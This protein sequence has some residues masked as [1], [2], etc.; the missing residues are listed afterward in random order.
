ML[1]KINGFYNHML[2]KM[3]KMI[4]LVIW[5]E[6]YPL[7][8]IKYKQ[9][10]FNLFIQSSPGSVDIPSY[11]TG[12]HETS[13]DLHAKNTG[14][15]GEK[16]DSGITNIKI[17]KPH[18]HSETPN[19]IA[20]NIISHSVDCTKPSNESCFMS[21]RVV[22]HEIS[23][24]SDIEKGTKLTDD[25]L[26]K[27]LVIPTITMSPVT[28]KDS[29]FNQSNVYCFDSET[30]TVVCTPP[31]GHDYIQTSVRNSDPN[32]GVHTFVTSDNVKSDNTS[33]AV[34]NS[35]R[36]KLYKGNIPKPIVYDQFDYRLFCLK[37]LFFFK[38]LGL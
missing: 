17:Q 5:T 22:S 7:A 29:Q 24:S 18:S 31:D 23:K 27:N 37:F 2:L 11:T 14:K 19:D 15:V 21:D 32:N 36:G 8:T 3:L 38:Y 4:E 13:K 30:T 28:D 12:Q 6:K 1:L 9:F 33:S 34:E 25:S 16:E 35:N 26:I 10:I 20:Q